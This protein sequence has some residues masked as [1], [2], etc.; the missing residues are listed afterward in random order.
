MDELAT[1]AVRAR[2]S[3]REPLAHLGLV[4]PMDIGLLLQL[5]SPMSKRARWLELALARS[6][7]VFADFSLK[8]HFERLYILTHLL[9]GRKLFLSLIWLLSVTWELLDERVGSCSR[10][11]V[12]RLLP[13]ICLF[14][15]CKIVK[16]G[17]A[18]ELVHLDVGLSELLRN[19]LGSVRL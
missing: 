6:L 9:L 8:L 10:E 16:S 11:K 18:S 1:S 5:V 14:F 17:W 3:L 15:V 4:I 2:S 13:F 7:P 19:N 12:W